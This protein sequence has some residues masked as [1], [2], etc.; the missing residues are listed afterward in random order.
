M[1][2]VIRRVLLVETKAVP[3]G[4]FVLELFDI[5]F[6]DNTDIWKKEK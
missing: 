5:S 3:V 1:E 2:G 6:D 4:P